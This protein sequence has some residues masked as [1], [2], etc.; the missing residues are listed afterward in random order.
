[1]ELV[2]GY[3]MSRGEHIFIPNPDLKTTGILACT[4]ALIALKVHFGWDVLLIL[5]SAPSYFAIMFFWSRHLRKRSN[6]SPTSLVLG[7]R[8][9]PS[10]VNT[11]LP[12]VFDA[13]RHRHMLITGQTGFG[14][15]TLLHRMILEALKKGMNLVYFDFK[16]ESKDHQSIERILKECGVWNSTQIFDLSLEKKCLGFDLFN[17]FET[18]SENVNF[19]LQTLLGSNPENHYY[20]NQSRSFLIQTITVLNAS[21]L[22]SINLKSIEALYSDTLFRAKVL[23]SASMAE[24]PSGEIRSAILFFKS[25]FDTMK[26]DRREER[27]S[28][29]FSELR[30]F[31]SGSLRDIFNPLDSSPR[32]EIRNLFKREGPTLIRVP[33]EKYGD[34]SRRIVGACMEAL[35]ILLSHHREATNRKHFFVILDEACSYMSSTI[36]D[37]LKKA[38]SADVHIVVTRMCDDDLRAVG[39]TASGRILASFD[40]HS[41]FHTTEHR[42]RESLAAIM[43]T[44]KSEKSTNRVSEGSE[45]GEQS[46]REVQ[47][48][49]HHPNIFLSLAPGEVVWMDT[50]ENS[51]YLGRIN[52]V[53]IAEK[54]EPLERST[55]DFL[56]KK[57]VGGE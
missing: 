19:V 31:N 34:V 49:I 1:M 16:G 47:Q 53:Q 8:L 33:G 13:S 3:S 26:P 10:K 44:S 50:R 17:N 12:L 11:G 35:P 56:E 29:L 27:Y 7:S 14:K 2:G 21:G 23:K 5:L 30:T 24:D 18:V 20:F 4:G 9:S 43:G 55:S 42:T 45:T 52:P 46:I 36:I 38:G 37:V 28:G 22:E 25:D 54:V 6:V 57:A 40:I 51:S 41:V 15:T 32:L 39:E 48:F